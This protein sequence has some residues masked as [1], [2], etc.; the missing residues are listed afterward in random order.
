MKKI[1]SLDL[2]KPQADALYRAVKTCKEFSD[3]HLWRGEF[4]PANIYTDHTTYIDLEK[5]VEDAG[6]RRWP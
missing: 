5:I 3:P 1:Y 2:T 4:T 6:L